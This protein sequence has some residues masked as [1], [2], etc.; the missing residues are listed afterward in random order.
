MARYR[1]VWK[2]VKGSDPPRFRRV[3]KRIEFPSATHYSEHFSRKELDCRCGCVTPPKIAKQLHLL[4]LDLEKLRTLLGGS[5]GVLSGYRCPARNRAVGGAS[6][7][8]HMRGTAADLVVPRGRQHE[9][10]AA[11]VK[12]P[13]FN[14]GGIGIYAHGGVHVDRRGVMARWNDWRRT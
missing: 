12:V 3:W 6:D 5:L 13:A 2:R 8:Q 10:V 11:A 9:F 4:A 7:S 14:H 1:R